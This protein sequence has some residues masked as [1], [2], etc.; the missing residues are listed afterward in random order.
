M[1]PAHTVET[2]TYPLLSQP[3]RSHEK[4]ALAGPYSA[5]NW[6]L[7]RHIGG[8]PGRLNSTSEKGKND[9][10]LQLMAR[11]NPFL[12]LLTVEYRLADTLAT[13]NVWVYDIEGN[14]LRKLIENSQARPTDT[15]VWD[16]LDESGTTVPVGAYIL[17][18]S[19]S[20]QGRFY[21]VKTVVVRG[22]EQ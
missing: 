19:A 16:G 21:D 10:R 15:V 14:L 1:A 20:V 13:I 7:S 3:G 4:V 5:G 8:S 18:A 17:Y 22:A 12:G 11:P 9:E 2:F 6:I